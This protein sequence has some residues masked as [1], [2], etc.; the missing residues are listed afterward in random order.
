MNPLSSLTPELDAGLAEL[1]IDTPG[2]T[3]RL[4]DYLALLV[5]WNR[6]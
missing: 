1:G 3:S 2:L 6:A 5:Q 4:L